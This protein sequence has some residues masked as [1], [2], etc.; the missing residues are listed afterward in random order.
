MTSAINDDELSISLPQNE[1]ARSRP[2]VP[3]VTSPPSLR[4]RSGQSLTPVA[5]S[6][7]TIRAMNR[8]HQYSFVRNIGEGSF[9]KVKLARHKVTGQEVAMKTINRRKLIS[10]DMAGRIEREIQY[11]Q[12]LRHPH[13]IKL[14]TVITTK[15]DIYMVLEYVPM[16]LFDYIV[17]HGRLGEAKARK[18]FQQIICA[19]EYCHRHKIVHRDLKPEN[20]LLDKNMNVKI[21]DFGLS[22]IMTDGN[23]LKTS[24]GSP[25]Y[26][27]P[28]VIGGKLYA[29]P[30]VDVWSC[31]VILYVFLVGRLPFDDEFIP[32]LFKKIQAG[33]FHIP[34]QTP[35]G[36]VNLIKRC[37]QVH[38]VHRITIPEIR[39]DEWF[40]KDLPAYLVDPVEEFLDTGVDPSKAIDPR[41]LAPG[42]PPEVVERIH[43]Q[44]VGKLG[45]TMGY[46][47]E[48]VK[49]AL[50]KDEPSAIK[51][52][53]LIVR[54]NQLMIDTPQYRAEN[55]ELE[56]FMA[57]S[58][59]VE[60]NFPGSPGSPPG[61]RRTQDDV[62]PL[63][64]TRGDGHRASRT[65]SETPSFQEEKPRIS[66]VR[67]LNTSL[68]HVHEE[69]MQ[70][71]EKAKSRGE[72]PDSILHPSQEDKDD[73]DSPIP[74]EIKDENGNPIYRSKEEQ[75]ATS[76]AL[77]PHSRSVTGLSNMREGKPRPEGLTTMSQDEKRAAASKPKPRKWQ[78]GI[79]S[80]NA[81]Y[82]AMKCLYAALRAQGADWEVNPWLLPESLPD[83]ED[84]K[85]M[86]PA[87]PP[88]LAPGERH[89]ILQQ[90]HSWLSEE[91]YVPRDPWNIR[92][93]VLKSGMLMPGEAPSLSAN[94]SAVS[95]PAEA[96][97]QLKKHIEQL[98]GYAS[99]DVAK[100]LGIQAPNG[101]GSRVQ[102]P[103]ESSTQQQAFTGPGQ[104]MSRPESLSALNKKIPSE[105]IGVWVFIDIQLY[106]LESG[107]Y[108]VDFKCDGYQNVIWHDPR[109][110]REKGKSSSSNSNVASP[111]A[112]RP[113]SG[114][115][116]L[117]HASSDHPDE[118]GSE[119]YWK[120]VSKRYKNVEKEI[121]SPY[122]FLDV[123]SDL[124]AQLWGGAA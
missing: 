104:P 77:K 73:S 60:P 19:V 33:T 122:P 11:L 79:R 27:A 59:P 81:P 110:E 53:Y 97:N 57:S 29:G 87:P 65:L 96:Q 51:D 30:E 105:H 44:V 41:Q 43:E 62:K 47:K 13:I 5:E 83:G 82:E 99:D 10:R 6:P 15:T 109:K 98:G 37:L 22:N 63:T 121:C 111:S 14:Y 106:T 118:E 67:V 115:G 26:A 88:E 54:E 64:P 69:L 61:S 24:C 56:S 20:L 76:R 74:E 32:A 8:L 68:P 45:R 72:D 25:N 103:G 49:D 16:E 100:A 102:S 46:A 39:Q 114:F 91:Y 108:V 92:A 120:P 7:G 66:N 93:R 116:D 123:A 12:L 58:P 119:G 40:V 84:E 4:Q 80:R 107:T 38:P 95:L 55:P 3:Q 113:T 28:E 94:S 117:N 34:S 9:G 70:L 85:D 17:K 75:E 23:F 90:K 101:S 71:R 50:S 86:I 42:K 1:H 48:D 112:S 89:T 31:G 2:S 52:A 36:A 18:L 78:F 124:V 21:A 35:P